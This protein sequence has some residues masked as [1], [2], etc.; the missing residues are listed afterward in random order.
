[1]QGTALYCTV[2]HKSN[3]VSVE[4]YY[5]LKGTVREIFY[6][7]F[8]WIYSKYMEPRFRGQEGFDFCFVFA[9]LFE[10][11]EGSLL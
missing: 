2:V 9:K 4:R 6:S 1:M 10:F 3:P 8:S 5:S 7:N 11:L